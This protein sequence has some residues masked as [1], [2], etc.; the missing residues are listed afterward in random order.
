MSGRFLLSVL[1]LAVVSAA[2]GAG[3]AVL[4]RSSD[5]DPQPVSEPAAAA[6]VPSA[7]QEA[8]PSP[9]EQTA[10]QQAAQEQAA[11]SVESFPANQEQAQPAEPAEPTDA[12][13]AQPQVEEQAQEQEA[14]QQ[15]VDEAAA[16]EQPVIDDPP[17]FDRATVSPT[18]IKQGEAFAVTVA[19][20]DARG[21][22]ATLGGRSWEL[23][24]SSAGIWWAIVAV[25]R[26]AEIGVT[27]LLIDLYG[28]GGVWLRTLTQ[29]ITVL[30]ST[31]PLEEIELGGTG[32]NP[33]P[34]EVARDIAVRFSQHTEITGPPRWQGAWILPVEGEVT[35]LFGAERSY[36]G[37]PS[38]EWHHGHDIAAQHGDPI[39]AP[40]HGTVVWTGELVLHG[41]G[42]IIDHGAGV[43]SGYWHMSLVAVREGFEVA[44]GDWLGNIGTTGL[45]TGPHLHWEVIIQGIDVDPVQWVGADRPPLP[46]SMEME[47]TQESADTIQ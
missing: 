16:E 14:Q 31:A 39:V 17:R 44:P 45:S 7:T 40:A 11:P 9:P 35:G 32:A 29:S 37:V 19:S 5:N 1:L 27:D 15:T 24:S 2:V 38:A 22:A 34:A 46:S 3:A 18:V 23:S 25:P 30:A 43:Y 12:V 41:M 13:A 4:L 36:D 28:E 6:T 20:A 21:A 42:T 26:D 8:E 33:D 10:Q 47:A